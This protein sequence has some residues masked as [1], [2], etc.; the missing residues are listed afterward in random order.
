V[1]GVMLAG[2]WNDNVL[3]EAGIEFVNDLAIGG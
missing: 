2:D 1:R 3:R